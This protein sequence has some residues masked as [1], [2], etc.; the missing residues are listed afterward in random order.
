MTGKAAATGAKHV[1]RHAGD[2]EG[3]AGVVALVKRDRFR[4]ELACVQQSPD[5]PPECQ[6][7]F[8]FAYRQAFFE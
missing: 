5:A 1:A 4:S 8:R 7:Q 2:I 6:A 3:L